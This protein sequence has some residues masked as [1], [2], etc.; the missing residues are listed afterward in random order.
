MQRTSIPCQPPRSSSDHAHRDELPSSCRASEQRV[1]AQGSALAS[2]PYPKQMWRFGFGA[3]FGQVWFML[4]IQSKPSSALHILWKVI[5]RAWTVLRR[6][7]LRCRR[8]VRGHRRRRPR[9]LQPPV[10]EIFLPLLQQAPHLLQTRHQT[11]IQMIQSL[12]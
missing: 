7:G 12:N 5:L 1:Q 10:Q 8:L 2:G 9:W 4:N 3:V 6:P 11:T